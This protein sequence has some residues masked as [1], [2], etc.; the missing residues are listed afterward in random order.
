[1]YFFNL[2]AISSYSFQKKEKSVRYVEERKGFKTDIE[3]ICGERKQKEHSRNTK[4]MEVEMN[5]IMLCFW[6]K[7][8][9]SLIRKKGTL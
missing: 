1:M 4:F 5:H 3:F 2:L 7:E 8:Q 9:N 6:N